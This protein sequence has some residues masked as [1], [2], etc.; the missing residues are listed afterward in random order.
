MRGVVKLNTVENFNKTFDTSTTGTTATYETTYCRHR[1]P[2][3][4]CE[5]FKCICPLYGSDYTYRVNEP[6][7]NDFV[8]VTCDTHRNK[9]STTRI[10]S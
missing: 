9:N 4:R 1:L 8:R 3:G 2:C 7:L 5:L 10:T 6:S